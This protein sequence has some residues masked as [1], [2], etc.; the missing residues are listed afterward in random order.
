MEKKAKKEEWYY[1]YEPAEKYRICYN[2]ELTDVRYVLG[3]RFNNDKEKALICIGINPSMALP[4][5]LD[6]TLAR[7]RKYAERKN[8]NY[9]AWYMLNVYPQRATDPQDMDKDE[10]DEEHA[11][12]SM[13][14]HRNN[15]NKIRELL[16]ENPGADIWCAWGTSIND[17]NRKFLLRL[18]VG[19]EK[20]DIEGLLSLFDKTCQFKVYGVTDEGYP[21]H[22]LLIRGE[23]NLIELCEEWVN[24]LKKTGKFSK[25]NSDKLKKHD[26]FLE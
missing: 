25:E 11:K 3:A 5:I 21:K 20:E 2:W 1:K 22:P 9:G 23:D 18:L 10:S 4:N 17:R 26:L 13:E 6:P 24:E 14:L 12:F 19:D 8:E 7:V 15:I 16:H